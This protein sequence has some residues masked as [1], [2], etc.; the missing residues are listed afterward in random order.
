M[1]KPPMA[2]VLRVIVR[3]FFKGTFQGL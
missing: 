3:I 1:Q 2:V